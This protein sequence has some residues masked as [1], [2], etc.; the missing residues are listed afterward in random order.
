MKAM[1]STPGHFTRTQWERAKGHPTTLP[2]ARQGFEAS[3]LLSS[4]LDSQRRDLTGRES[5]RR[6]LQRRN[7]FKVQTSGP[8]AGEAIMRIF[9]ENV[10][11]DRIKVKSNE[12]IDIDLKRFALCEAIHSVN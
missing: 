9:S 4:D 1:C 5:L 8:M 10:L 12:E 2:R 7:E 3:L 11:R 6:T